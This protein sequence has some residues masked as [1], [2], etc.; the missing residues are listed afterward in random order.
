MTSVT[1]N[2][3]FTCGKFTDLL[4]SWMQH[5]TAYKHTCKHIQY[6]SNHNKWSNNFD[7]RL[8]HRG[9]FIFI[10]HTQDQESGLKTH[11]YQSAFTCL[12]TV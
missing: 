8:H 2:T 5:F 11:W 12:H 4:W 3:M 6:Y 7:K 10:G 9:G 1:C